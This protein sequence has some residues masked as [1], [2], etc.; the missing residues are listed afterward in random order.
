MKWRVF[1]AINFSEELQ[2]RFKSIIALLQNA[3]PAEKVGWTPVHNLH[4]TLGF[5][6]NIQVEHLT[7]LIKNAQHVLRD[8]PAFHLQLDRLQLFPSIM[9]PR[10]ISLTLGPERC[11][12]ELAIKVRQAICATH[13]PV[14]ARAFR[15][16]LTLARLHNYHCKKESL[17]EIQLPFIPDIKVSTIYLLESKLGKSPPS[18]TPLAHFN[19]K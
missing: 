16:H 5:L 2:Q 14:E 4:V 3:I 13:Y 6:G 7:Q 12:S 19:L 15:G 8:V 10:I 18:Y 17:A 11:L 9:K 1:F